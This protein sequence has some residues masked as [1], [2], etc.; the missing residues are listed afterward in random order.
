MKKLLFILIAVLVFTSCDKKN[1]KVDILVTIYPFKFILQEIVKDELV[2]NVLLTASIDPH[3]YEMV[4][5]DLIKVQKAEL[6]IYGD[7][8]LDGWASK[9]EAKNKIQLSD[10]LPDTLRLNISEPLSN[11]N[12]TVDHTHNQNHS[13]EGFDPHF[14]TDPITVKGMT[15]NI[16]SLLIKHFPDKKYTF[17]ANS[18]I[19]KSKLEQLD[20]NIFQKTKTIQNRNIFSSHPFYNYFFKRYEFNIVGFL[21]VSPGQVLSPKEMKMMMDVVKKNNVKAIFTN[22]Q[23]S[24]RTTK[25]LAESVGIKYYV[26]DP[27][28]GTENL[29]DYVSVVNHNLE[30][31]AKALK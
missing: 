26:L 3:T 20:S 11:K 14:W 31:I 18:E 23:H 21:E 24:D 8:Q 29:M 13:H 6:F 9:L 28:G 5:S 17:I 15:N 4:P 1:Y 7:K 10:L 27:I 30:I 16:V 2:I 25:I 22:K 19:F 12:L